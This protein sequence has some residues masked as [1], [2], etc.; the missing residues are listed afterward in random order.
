MTEV[1]PIS[2]SEIASQKL[3]DIPSFVFSIV[4]KRLAAKYV[5]G[6]F[7]VT[8]KQDDIIADILAHKPEMIRRDVFDN[9]WLNI[10]E[11]YRQAGWD[12]H[13]DSPGYNESYDAFF[14]FT[15]KKET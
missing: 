10:E 6:I 14:K 9:G 4:N 11:V 2:P 8:I 1:K 12:V 3:K 15:P 13:Y 7:E 5:D